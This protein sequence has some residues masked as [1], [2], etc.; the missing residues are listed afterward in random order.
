MVG[1]MANGP[2]SGMWGGTHEAVAPTTA[3]GR[4]P[5]STVSQHPSVIVPENGCG[6]GVGTGPTGLGIRRMWTSI[7]VTTSV[8]RAAGGIVITP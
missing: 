2:P 5:M 7:P 4:P 3:A 8:M 6:T 1:G